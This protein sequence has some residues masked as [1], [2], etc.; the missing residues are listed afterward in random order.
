MLSGEG[1]GGSYSV[2]I[3]WSYHTMLC[4]NKHL[5]NVLYWKCDSNSAFCTLICQL[6]Q[7]HHSKGSFKTE[8]IIP[9]LFPVLS[10]WIK[11]RSIQMAFPNMRGVVYAKFQPDQ[12]PE[13]VNI[14]AQYKTIQFISMF[15][16]ER[17]LPLYWAFS[18]LLSVDAVLQPRLHV[19]PSSLGWAHHP[20]SRTHWPTEQKG[21]INATAHARAMTLVHWAIYEI[22]YLPGDG[23]LGDFSP[24]ESL[25]LLS[26]GTADL[27]KVEICN[28]Q[29]PAKNSR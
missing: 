25:C 7:A 21:G 28:F 3:Y 16:W 9:I 10:S 2:H 11:L 29:S 20:P 5:L 12:S 24:G 22:R 8:Q 17:P 13:L 26:N 27:V 18:R 6:S 1:G 19:L 23:K 4:T 14:L 15:V